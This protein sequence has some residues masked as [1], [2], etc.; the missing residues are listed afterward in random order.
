MDMIFVC[1]DFHKDDF[2]ALC[3]ASA[4]IFERVFGVVRKDFLAAFYRTD[5]VVEN[6]RNIVGFLHVLAQG[7]HPTSSVAEGN[8]ASPRESDPRWID[9]VL[10]FF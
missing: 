3:N 9:I 4:D 7:C 6:E 8:G 10:H 1:S 5:Q 2:I